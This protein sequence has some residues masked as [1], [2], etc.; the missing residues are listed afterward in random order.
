M[1]DASIAHTGAASKHANMM[2]ATTS[3]FRMV[4]TLGGD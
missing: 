4:L 1:L 2:K 3:Q